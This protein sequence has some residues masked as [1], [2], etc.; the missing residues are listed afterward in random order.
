MNHKRNYLGACG[1]IIRVAW[2]LRFVARGCLGCQVGVCG[3]ALELWWL[4]VC[5]GSRRFQAVNGK[6][7]TA[8]AIRP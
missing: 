3:A 4:G 6:S 2:I 5:Y 8:E 7:R 1:C